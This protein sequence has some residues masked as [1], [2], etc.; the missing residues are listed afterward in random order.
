MNKKNIWI[1]TGIIA[2][3]IPIIA[4]LCLN[5]FVWKDEPAEVAVE[6]ETVKNGGTIEPVGTQGLYKFKSQYG[7]KLNYNPKYNVDLSGEAYDF[8][9]YNDDKS[10]N[11]AVTISNMDESIASVETKEDWDAAMGEEMGKCAEF[12]KTVMNGMETMVAHYYFGDENS[13]N[14]VDVLVAAMI[15]KEYIYMYCYTATPDANETEAQQIGAIL[16]TITE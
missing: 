12:N 2:I 4:V 11:V 7:Y 14:V 15:G 6:P 16:Y 3:M 5:A 9:I 10:V 1:I 13:E 8:Y